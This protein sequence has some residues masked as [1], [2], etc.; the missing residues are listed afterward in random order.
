MGHNR[1]SR[2]ATAHPAHVGTEVAESTS[3]DVWTIV[4]AAGRGRRLASLTQRLYGFALPK[5]FAVLDGSSSLL[6][7]TVERLLPLTS[8]ERT[9]VVVPSAHE[10]RAR[11][12]LSRWSGVHVVAQPLDRGTAPGVM[13]PLAYVPERSPAASVCVSPSDHHFR[14]DGAARRS[15]EAALVAAETRSM[16]L[17]GARPTRPETEYGW[18]VPGTSCAGCAPV[19][20]F[21]EKP[22]A[23]SAGRLF[24]QGALWNT[25]L[26]VARARSLWDRCRRHLPV[27]A[28]AIDACHPIGTDRTRSTLR[29]EYARLPTRDFSRDVLQRDRDIG[30]V[31]LAGSGWSDLGTPERA[32]DALGP[33]LAGQR[34]G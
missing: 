23:N 13:L 3:V 1:G 31:E 2:A 32:L 11:A 25:F 24:E 4:L 27:H 28:S 15:I 33:L 8:P 30:V 7:R 12:M 14:D 6:E 21:V 22:D 20:H 34:A 16:V 26:V 9:V 29:N 10:S 18:I 17:V 5:Q 19:L